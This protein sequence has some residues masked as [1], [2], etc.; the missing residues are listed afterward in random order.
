MKRKHVKITYTF[1][2]AYEHEKHFKDIVREL[3]EHPILEVS[4]AG[5]VD[6]R[7]YGYDYKRIGKG[8]IVKDTP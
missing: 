6:G 1:S 7:S 4:G 8:K 5:M 3:K 2:V